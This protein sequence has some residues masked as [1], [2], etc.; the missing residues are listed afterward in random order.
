VGLER[1]LAGWSPEQHAELAQ[2]LDRPS[3]APVA[4]DADRHLIAT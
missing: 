1:L 2:M 4:E 3:T